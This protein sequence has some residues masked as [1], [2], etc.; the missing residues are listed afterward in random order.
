MVVD[1]Q[2]AGGKTEAWR[3]SPGS[4]IIQPHTRPQHRAPALFATSIDAEEAAWPARDYKAFWEEQ[5]RNTYA[6]GQSFWRPDLATPRHFL[7]FLE[8]GIVHPPAR[9]L[10]IGCS[11]GLNPLFLHRQGYRVTGVD[12]SPSAID[13]ARQVAH[14]N[15]ADITLLCQDAAAGPLDIPGCYDLWV[16]IKVLHCLWDD[17][18]R[19][20][21]YRNAFDALVPNGLFFLTCGLALCDVRAYFP[22]VFAQLDEQTRRSAD[23]PLDREVPPNSAAASAARRS[24]TIA[25]SAR[26]P[27]S[28]S[29]RLGA[30]VGLKTGWGVV[31][32]A[33][34]PAAPAPTT[35]WQ[36]DLRGISSLVRRQLAAAL[37]YECYLHV[38]D[39]MAN[40]GVYEVTV[41]PPAQPEQR[42]TLKRPLDWH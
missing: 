24:T 14:E 12:V 26:Q 30:S 11:D 25:T 37:E 23:D 31:L 21:Y 3:T 17:D 9:V 33:R 15:A 41:Q 1:A 32:I 27:A 8:S 5:H 35:S 10:E 4:L 38:Y 20:M 7:A 42:L 16:D 39:A 18:A 29:S 28:R 36:P 19:A 6:S 22:E 34:K 40:P 2:Q 13:R